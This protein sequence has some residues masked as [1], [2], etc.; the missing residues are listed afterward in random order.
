M[1]FKEFFILTAFALTPAV[2]PQAQTAKTWIGASADFFEAANWDLGTVPGLDPADIA[3]IANGGTGNIG[4]TA[5]TRTFGG[6]RLAPNSGSNESG[7]VVMNAGTLNIG[8]T[9]GDPKA[10]IGNSAVLSTF[11]MNGGTIF[12]DGP[13]RFPGSRGDDGLN[14]L[15]W[16]VGEQGVG[17]FEMHGDAVFRA[18]DDLKVAENAAGSGSVLIDGNARLSLGSG[19]SLSA[20]GEVEQTMVIGGNAIVD[21]GNSMGAGNPQG[22]TDEGYL[23]MATSNGKAKLTIQENGV[24]NIRRLTAREGVSTILVKDRGQFHIFDV[25]TGTGGSPANRP[26]EPGVGSDNNNSTYGSANTSDATLTVQDDAQVTVSSASEAGPT[27]G[28]GIS[29]QRGGGNPGGKAKLTV[30]DRASLRIVQE[31]MLGTGASSATSDGTLEVEGAAATVVIS[32]NLNMAVD[33]EGNVA[34]SDVT[35]DEGNPVPGKATLMAVITGSTHTTVNVGGIA[36]I[37]KG[38]LKVMTHGHTPAEGTVYTLIKGGTIE[39]QFASTDFTEAPLGGA[40]TWQV[41]YAADAVRLKVAGPRI[42]TVTTANN[43]N[44]PAGTTSLLQALT[45][46]QD[47]DT[48]RF[49]IAGDGPHVITT[50]VG[51][52]PLIAASGVTIDGYSQPGASANSNPIL[53]GNNAKIQIV[54]DSSDNASSPSTDPENALL[55]QRRSTRLPYPGYGDTENAILGVLGGD[56]FSVKGISFLGRRTQP[57]TGAEGDEDAGDTSVSDPAI[58]AV[59]LI[60]EAKNAKVQGCWFGLAPDGTTVKPLNAAVAGFRH[61]VSVEGANVDTFSGGLVFGTDGDG[62]NDTAE[63]NIAIGARIALAIELPDARI[64]GNYFNV[65]PNGL[66]FYDMEA[67]S[68]ELQGLGF[69]SGTLESI[70]N[71]RV[72]DNTIIGTD[73]NGVSD[74]NERNIFAHSIYDVDIEFYTAGLNAVIAGNYFGVGVDGVTAQ[75]A[76]TSASPNFLAMPGTASVRIGSNGD[77][78]SDALEG[79]LI[80]NMAGSTF[81]DGSASVPIVARQNKLVKNAFA[82]FPF[83]EGQNGRAYEAYYAEALEN[84]AAGAVP[85]LASI[86][87]GIMSGTVPAPNLANYP[88]H[89]IDVYMVDPDLPAIPATYVTSFREGS[90]QDLDPAAN[91]FRFS[92]IGTSATPGSKIA[93]AV[94]YAKVAGATQSTNAVTGP[95]SAAVDANIPEFAPGSIESVGLRRITAD[96]V[97]ASP[98]AD[99]LGNWEPYISVLGTNVFL[100]EGNTFADGTTDQQRY[101]VYLQP[102]DGSAGK[103]AEAFYADNGTAYKGQINLSRPNGNPGRVAGDKRPGAKNYIAG[104]ETS[105]HGVPSGGPGAFTADNRWSAN[106]AYSDVNR[107]ATVQSYSLDTATL[108]PTPLTKAFDAVNGGSTSTFSGNVPEVSRFGGELAV[109]DNGNYVVVIDDR[110]NLIAPRRTATAAIITPA[111]QV[112]K[113]G[114]AIDGDID[115]QIWSNVA[116]HKGGFC[117]RFATNLYFYD[118]AGNLLRKVAQSTSGLSLQT[119]RGDGTR[120]ASHINSTFVFLAGRSQVANENVVKIAAW[121][122]SDFSFAGFADVSEGA[123]TGGFD[124]ANLAVDALNRV[125][126]SWVSQPAGYEQQQVAA[127]VMAFNPATK[128]FTALTKSFLPFA[129][130]AQTGG[131]RSLGMSVAMTTERICIAAKGEVNLQNNPGQGAN[132]PREVNF[133]TVITHPD[134]QLD[135]T[136]RADSAGADLRITSI[137]ASANSIVIEWSG[138][139]APYLVQKKLNFGAAQQW[140]NLLTTGETKAI[141][142]NDG[143]T[144]FFRVG[145]GATTTVIPLNA[146]MGGA[147]EKPNAVN[148]PARGVAMA[149]IEG[150]TLSFDVA[151]SGLTGPATL[152]HIHGYGTTADARGVILNLA[153]FNGGAFGSSGRLTGSATLTDEQ[154]TGILAGDTYFNIHTL[155]NGGGEI[156]GQITPSIMKVA[157]NGANEKPTAVDTPATGTGTVT[158]A[159]SEVFV[160]VSYTGLKQAATAAHI[161]GPADA[162]A[163]AGVMLDI[164]PMHVGA[165]GTSGRFNGRALLTPAQLSMIIDGLTYVNIHSGA[166]GGGEIRGQIV[167]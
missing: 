127:R 28:L 122:A 155:A 66:T 108:T 120:I 19:I 130:N 131:L 133:F 40:S 3:I 24:L 96:T 164:Q 12:F 27:R 64:S 97:V 68:A 44:P 124:R 159:G 48:I 99:A 26:A 56:N 141:V 151:Y 161:H 143:T 83:A 123:F 142:P 167:P 46:L 21:S 125:T 160:D 45:G 129:N 61:R 31:L 149:S 30:K 55:Q 153:P 113:S 37:G 42:V 14:G 89:V 152:A 43:A 135:P 105:A 128:S 81:V 41:E 110:S 104:G 58:Y 114:F 76:L 9:E 147:F 73:G 67:A 119:D 62:S 138:G 16:E 59:A 100:I 72:T 79:N 139:T 7:H 156:R 78:V 47:G 71:G 166:H 117:V 32:G 5:G 107:Y 157:M 118:N 23:T 162:S 86:T 65:F 18:G 6:I 4:T 101:V 38:H 82:G 95:L 52:Y 33:L 158:I 87:E 98:A 49:N 69:S 116:A 25:L 63:F 126:V 115:A 121:D 106:G 112:V 1:K 29:A 11:I 136:P 165:F 92:L 36:R 51:G 57:S 148:T 54:L 84:S 145:S 74:G 140:M 88:S 75:A 150:S 53:G 15:D 163:F 8:G 154:K 102:V 134:P 13:D 93:V 144:A 111:G 90:A 109:L 146:V 85:V 20:G 91:A 77:G 35:D 94:T 50:P 103:L 34:A 80:Y 17:R 10:L 137:D 60:R 22:S 132:S 2:A 39:G 70:E